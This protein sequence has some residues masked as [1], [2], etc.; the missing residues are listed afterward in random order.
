VDKIIPSHTATF[1][2]DYDLMLQ[3]ARSELQQKAINDF[4]NEKIKTTY[5]I[6]DP[7]FKDCVF[8]REGWHE[9]IRK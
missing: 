2:N 4:I 8:E 1:T 6:I 5:I 3:H 7:L 9:K